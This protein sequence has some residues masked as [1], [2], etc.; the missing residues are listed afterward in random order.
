MKSN[1]LPGT[2]VPATDDAEIMRSAISRGMLLDIFDEPIVFNRAFVGITGSAVASL[3]LSYAIY[4][5][6]RLVAESEGWFEKTFD[7]WKEET[8]LTR[9]EQRA[10]R[11]ILVDLDILIER[12]VGMPAK[13]MFK[14][15]SERLLEL[16]RQQSDMRWGG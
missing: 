12:R 14:I 5:T 7:E 9:F 3:F 13:L 10:A 16:L 1:K 2:L 4:T 11:K 15:R 6:D 8:G